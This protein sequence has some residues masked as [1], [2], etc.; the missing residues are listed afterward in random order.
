MSLNEGELAIGIGATIVTGST[1]TGTVIIK[2]AQQHRHSSPDPEDVGLSCVG[3]WDSAHES[4]EHSAQN[5]ISVPASNTI[6][7]A[8]DRRRP[9]HANL[10]VIHISVSH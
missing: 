1:W 4:G 8:I 9:E 3:Q 7:T 6:A 2:C 10:T 5:T